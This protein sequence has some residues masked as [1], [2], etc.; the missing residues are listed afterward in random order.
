[1]FLYSVTGLNTIPSQVWLWTEI[2]RIV[3]T[4]KECR[5][6]LLCRPKQIKWLILSN[7]SLLCWAGWIQLCYLALDFTLISKLLRIGEYGFAVASV[8]LYWPHCER[9]FKSHSL[10]W[11]RPNQLFAVAFARRKCVGYIFRILTV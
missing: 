3:H 5:V 11:L 9:F 6:S 1:M 8:C 7:Y 4:Y 2:F 10:R